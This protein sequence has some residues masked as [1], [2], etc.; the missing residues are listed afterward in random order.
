M[1]SN[2]KRH[3]FIGLVMIFIAGTLL[4]VGIYL[5]VWGAVRP[6]LYG[7]TPDFLELLGLKNLEE[8]P[9]LEELSIALRSPEEVAGMD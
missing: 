6:L 3:E 2:L 8:L 5:T 9:R 7:T 1:R 4:G